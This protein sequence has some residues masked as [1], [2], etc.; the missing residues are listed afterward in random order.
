MKVISSNHSLLS[1]SNTALLRVIFEAMVLVHHL[2][3]TYTALGAV[4][5]NVFGPVAVGGF[6]FVSGY[7]VGC[8]FTQKNDEYT[9]K[10]IKNRVPR[11]YA[12]LLIVNLCYLGLFLATGGKFDNLFSA[13]I[14]V[15]YMPVFGGFVAL[16]HWIYFLADLI[17]Y[18]LLFAVFISLFKNTKNRLLWTAVAIL[19]LDLV[20]IA[21][22]SAINFQTGS[23][24]YLRAC[25]CF[26][27][28]LLCA[29]FSEKI[30]ETV[31]NNKTILALCLSVVSIASVAFFNYRSINEYAL[32]VFAVLALV[33]MLYGVNTQSRVVH[34]L[35]GLV[36]YVY[37]SHEF[38][39]I[40][41]Q[42][43]FSTLHRN[44]IGLIVFACAMIFAIL[45]NSGV[46]KC[47][48]SN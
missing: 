23:S 17:I 34:Y 32:P 12:M 35:S 4:I 46:R 27:I 3:A 21:V 45:L 37:V 39:L 2:Y 13:I 30:A 29:A 1:H 14:S 36:V 15:L 18:Y 22:L 44:M 28:G 16:S 40:V 33:I 6:V 10:L 11:T 26:P 5:T 20:I 42:N 43:L 31:K 25:L 9:K 19:I 48:I 8:R 24:R 47:G 41:C 7:G 38:F